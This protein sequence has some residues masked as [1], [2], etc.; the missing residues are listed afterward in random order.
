MSIQVHFNNI[1]LSVISIPRSKL[2]I[3][4]NPI[5]QLLYD[6]IPEEDKHSDSGPSS[7]DGTASDDYENEGEDTETFINSTGSQISTIPAASRLIIQA[8]HNRTKRLQTI[9]RVTITRD[10][11]KAFS[12]LG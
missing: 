9:L 10:T 3:F 6:S 7:E 2:W 1:E 11:K 8:S 12:M 4:T 5:I